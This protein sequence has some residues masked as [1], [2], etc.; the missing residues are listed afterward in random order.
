MDHYCWISLLAI[1]DNYPVREEEVEAKVRVK[2]NYKVQNLKA[3]KH[4]NP[5]RKHP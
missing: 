5:K 3:L 1:K 2:H 4:N